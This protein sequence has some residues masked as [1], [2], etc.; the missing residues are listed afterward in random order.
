MIPHTKVDGGAVCSSC[1]HHLCYHSGDVH[2]FLPVDI[3]GRLVVSCTSS[4]NLLST[5]G[6]VSTLL[7]L[8]IFRHLVLLL[9]LIQ[10]TL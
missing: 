4:S 2:Y 8:K 3:T 10:Y 6:F 1:M 7:L 5:Y 9:K